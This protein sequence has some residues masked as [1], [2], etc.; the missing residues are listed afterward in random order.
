MKI[1]SNILFNTGLVEEKR[2]KVSNL[3]H[4]IICTLVLEKA[5]LRIT[6]V[7]AVKSVPL[8]AYLP[9][10]TH[11]HVS[12][13]KQ[14][15]TRLIPMIWIKLDMRLRRFIHLL[16]EIRI[17]YSSDLLI[18]IFLE[19]LSD[20]DVFGFVNIFKKQKNFKAPPIQ[21]MSNFCFVER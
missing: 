19:L 20:K 21:D 17:L 2:E 14:A 6:S 1:K 11:T 13:Y 10:H 4:T 12:K 9:L 8:L 7:V 15:S 16:W 5:F 3:F 18:I